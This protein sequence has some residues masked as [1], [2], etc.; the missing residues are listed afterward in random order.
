MTLHNSGGR[1]RKLLYV[2]Q[3]WWYRLHH[4]HDYGMCVIDPVVLWDGR[5][6]QEAHVVYNAAFESI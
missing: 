3:E 5:E 2:L 6:V 4:G 1:T